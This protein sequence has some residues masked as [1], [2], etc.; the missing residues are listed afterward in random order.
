MLFAMRA[1]CW[2]IFSLDP[3]RTPPNTNTSSSKPIDSQPILDHGAKPPAR[4]LFT[5]REVSFVL[6]LYVYRGHSFFLEEKL[7]YPSQIIPS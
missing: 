3:Q 2:L 7:N 5:L 6:V 1:R 4:S